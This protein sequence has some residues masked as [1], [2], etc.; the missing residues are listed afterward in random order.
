MAI[1]YSYPVEATPT[2]SDLLL[3]TSVAADNKP[4][5]SFTIASLAALVSANAGTGTVTNV[6]TANS[7]FINMTGGPI[8]TSG[9]LQA[10]LSASGTPSST[11]F[12]RGDNTWAPATSTGS[13]NISV[14]DEGTEIVTAVESLNF[15]GAGVDVTA[16]G[17]VAVIDIPSP[18][19]AVTS[20][21]ASTGIS[22]DQATGDVTVS[23]T[24]ITSLIAGTN[25]TLSPA[26]GLGNVVINATNNPGTVQ[27][28][29]PGNGLQ[30]DSGVLTSNP[31]LGME[32]DGSNNYILVGKSSGA[33]PAA[34]TTSDDFIAYNQLSS[35]EVKT[36]TFATLPTTALPLVKQY[37]DDGDANTIKNTND[38]F[39]TTA[40][41]NNIVT[42]TDVEYANLVAAA[43]TNPNT[44]Y[45]AILDVNK[46]SPLTVNFATTT[47]GIIDETGAT[48]P[49]GDYTLVTRVNGVIA[50][51][52]TGCTD[53]AYEVVTTAT[54]AAGYYFEEA[55]TGNTTTGLI[56]ATTPV[57]QTLVGK[58]YPNPTPEIE[59]TLLIVYDVQG[60]PNP[61]VT[62]TGTDGGVTGD[63][64]TAAPGSTS[65]VVNG[66]VT[67]A[68]TPPG[69]YTWKA[70]SPTVVQASG[71]IYGSQTVI[72]TVTGTLELT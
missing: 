72:T 45:I 55:L 1:I 36:T 57:T 64:Q 46:C 4:T 69:G 52:I 14:L 63:T 8:S 24:G 29:V 19:G 48:A 27:S 20:L 56:S 15:T 54:P 23:N 67:N 71:T 59:A 21:I 26:T 49:G 25:I 38:T 70:G 60:G 28:V 51:S 33:T 9:I 11:T 34:V 62:G 13:P 3:G 35:S 39:N 66:F 53:E 44:L 22:V 2:T 30:L 31:V 17:N 42:L 40:T 32:Y 12:L 18:T 5:K 61:T 47:T 41:I 58:V 65:L 16:S 68:S 7:T 6:A 37:I 50:S 10:S 43:A